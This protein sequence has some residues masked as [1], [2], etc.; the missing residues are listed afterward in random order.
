[1][2]KNCIRFPDPFSLAVVISDQTNK[3]KPNLIIVVCNVHRVIWVLKFKNK[4]DA[5]AFIQTQT[6]RQLVKFRCVKLTQ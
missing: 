2:A 4:D 5:L 3:D 1:M 6:D